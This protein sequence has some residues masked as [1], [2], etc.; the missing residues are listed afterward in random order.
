[1]QECMVVILFYVF[2]FK[3]LASYHVFNFISI[4]HSDKYAEKEHQKNDIENS[5]YGRI[6]LRVYV[7]GLVIN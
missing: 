4:V 5:Q 6:I 3:S 1:M 7:V 2:I